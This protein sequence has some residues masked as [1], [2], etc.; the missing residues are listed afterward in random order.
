MKAL[1]MKFEVTKKIAYNPEF[2][3]KVERSL[4]QIEDGKTTEIEN[5]DEF[6]GVDK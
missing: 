4:K 3:E 1:K 5:I 6:L 2:T